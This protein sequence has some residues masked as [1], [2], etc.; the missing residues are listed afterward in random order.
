MSSSGS[1]LPLNI[2]GYS[3]SIGTRV[4]RACSLESSECD[5]VQSVGGNGT[6]SKPRKGHLGRLHGQ[7][8]PRS[9]SSNLYSAGSSTGYT[10]ASAASSGAKGPN[11]PS[12]ESF[13]P[14]FS[15]ATPYRTDVVSA[16]GGNSL[17]EKELLL[18]PV[19][20]SIPNFDDPD[21]SRGSLEGDDTAVEEELLIL[22]TRQTSLSL[23]ELEEMAAEEEVIR[24]MG[25]RNN[26]ADLCNTPV[27]QMSFLS[28]HS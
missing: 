5:D 1:F 12:A 15:P 19:M 17:D 4:S 21:G 10:T 11:S 16:R 3:F 18:G 8:T 26:R 7:L 25:S 20:D 22:R 27:D 2:D 28:I 9:S 14:I 24:A 23:E 6:G 13:C